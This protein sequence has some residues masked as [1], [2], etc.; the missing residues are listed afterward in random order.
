MLRKVTLLI[1]LIA[2]VAQGQTLTQTTSAQPVV[3]QRI[4]VNA[5]RP[6]SLTMQEAIALALENNRD[7]EVERINVQRNQFE[8]AAAKGVF[9]PTMALNFSYSRN[10][11]PVSSLLAGGENGKLQSSSL[12]GKTTFSKLLPWQGGDIKFSFENNRLASQNL[13]NALDPEYRTG[14]NLEYTQPL[15]RNRGIDS[16]RRQIRIKA[17][18]LDLSDIQFRRRV[19]EIITQVKNAYWDL[20]FAYRNEEIKRESVQLAQTQLEY[21]QRLVE[22]E[23]LAPSDV[24]SARVEIERRTDEAEAALETVQ[25]AENALKM[26]MLQPGQTELW[27]AMLLPVD[28]PQVDSPQLLPLEDA[29]KIALQNRPEMEQYQVRADLN[30][31]NVEYYRNQTRPEV[32][33]IAGYGTTGLAGTERTTDNP[34]TAAIDPFFSRINQLLQLAGL[35]LITTG[36]NDRVAPKFVGGYGQS[37]SNLF[38]NEFRSWQVGVNINF[39]LGNRTAKAQLGQA[40]AEEG[41][42]DV[43]RQ[44]TQQEIE[45]EVRNALQA[46]SSAHRRVEAASNSRIDAQLQYQA[47]QRKFEAGLSTNFLILDRQNALSSAHGREVKAFTDYNKAKTDLERALSTTTQTSKV[48]I[49]HR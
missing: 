41:Q 25:R 14:I 45:V 18:Q 15:W 47:E 31:V 16:A 35:P 9:D 6:I 37:L 19:T 7:I 12:S 3:S 10:N 22:K 1:L 5:A 42:I 26:L 2:Q 36:L 8:L 13:F 38:G 30:K 17:K 46:V 33:L 34:I 40:L 48:V 4:G 11:S 32:N 29:V 49:S 44:R 23:L 24:I 21:N 28:Q 43:E 39:S 20:V 27:N